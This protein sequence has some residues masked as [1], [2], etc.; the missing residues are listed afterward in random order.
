M[1]E[2]PEQEQRL[3]AGDRGCRRDL[4][5]ARFEAVEARALTCSVSVLRE[6]F[7]ELVAGVFETC[8]VERLGGARECL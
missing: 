5:T 4:S 8:Q 2:I 7:N 6:A 1:P 3:E